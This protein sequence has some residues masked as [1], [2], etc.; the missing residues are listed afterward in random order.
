MK[1]FLEKNVERKGKHYY[2]GGV[3]LSPAFIKKLAKVGEQK[4]DKV[5]LNK[6]IQTQWGKDL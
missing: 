4:K 5:C 2:R 1:A 3:L 6:E